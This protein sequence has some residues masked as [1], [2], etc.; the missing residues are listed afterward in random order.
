VNQHHYYLGSQPSVQT[1]AK[2]HATSSPVSTLHLGSVADLAKE[3]WEGS[4]I[5]R[6]VG[7]ALPPTWQS[8]GGQLISQSN[9]LVDEISNRFDG[10]LTMIDQGGYEGKER[11]IYA[12]QPTEM[13]TPSPLPGV[14]QGEKSLS[15]TS[16]K[17]QGKDRRKSQTTAPPTEVSGSI[18]ARVDCYANSRLPMNLPPLRLYA[19]V[20]FT[21]VAVA[22]ETIRY[23]PTYPLLCLAAQYSERVYEPPT[24]CAE[25]D[26]H[27]GADWWTGTKAMVIKSVPM[28]HMNTIVFAIRGTA[29]FMDWSVNL[30]MAPTSPVGFLV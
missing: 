18:F 30:K 14:R 29:T 9:A 19:P 16:R 25:R 26:A 21:C 1:A 6:L 4:G 28:D 20:N 23:I 5:P 8:C 11:D 15:M 17:S 22:D 7:D 24:G 3:V 10:V 12:W 13:S 27:V 2:P